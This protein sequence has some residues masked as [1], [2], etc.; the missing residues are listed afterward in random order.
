M[1]LFGHEENC[2]VGSVSTKISLG[3]YIE[4]F[5]CQISGTLLGGGGILKKNVK[6]ITSVTK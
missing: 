3:A 2:T 1:E 5:G 4:N 6:W